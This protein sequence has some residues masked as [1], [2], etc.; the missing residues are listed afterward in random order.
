M[1]VRVDEHLPYD[2]REIIISFFSYSTEEAIFTPSAYVVTVSLLQADHD[3]PSR[4]TQ[5]GA[6][7]QSGRDGVTS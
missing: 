5:A 1:R 6:A 3:V 7:P 2:L 4:T